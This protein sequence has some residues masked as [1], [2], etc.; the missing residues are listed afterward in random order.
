[1]STI[2]AIY[3]A[4]KQA[5]LDD[6]TARDLYER[7]TGERSLRKMTP[8]QQVKVL[9]AL[10]RNATRPVA[11]RLDGPYAK[12]LQALWISAW[13]LGIVH[14]RRDAALLSF[15]H[16]QTGIDHTR[17]LRDAADARRA[18]E[19]LKKWIGRAAN[20]DWSE[21]ERDPLDAVIEAQGVILKL[22][23]A[24]IDSTDLDVQAFFAWRR[25]ELSQPEK[26]AVTRQLGETIRGRSA[27]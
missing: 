9:Q 2:S 19:A 5:G 6:D 24:D 13:N 27:R 10:R 12:K 11:A 20:I 16:R 18:V 4:R 8:G 22:G 21:P 25:D 14:D 15:V 1:M 7:E 23:Q 17:F 3:G 26:I